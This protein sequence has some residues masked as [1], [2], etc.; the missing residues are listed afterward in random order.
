MEETKGEEVKEE[1]KTNELK[2][3]VRDW[4]EC[5]QE[6]VVLMKII[7]A[8]KGQDKVK[9]RLTFKNGGDGPINVLLPKSFLTDSLY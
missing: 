8:N 3:D 2:V 1:V 9:F 6:G 4:Y 7:V 5:K